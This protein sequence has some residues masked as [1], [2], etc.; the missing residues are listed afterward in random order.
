MDCEA[1]VGETGAALCGSGAC[2]GSTGGVTRSALGGVP[3]IIQI[4]GAGIADLQG[5]VT[6][7]GQTL[8]KGRARTGV[9]GRCT[10]R[11]GSS[12]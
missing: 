2:T 9:A 10:C 11:T 1:C 6:E 7:T 8:V 4:A 5:S 12:D 3:V